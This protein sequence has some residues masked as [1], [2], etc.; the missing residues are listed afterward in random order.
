MIQKNNRSPLIKR[1]PVPKPAL[2]LVNN[3]DI[4]ETV[5][6]IE[7][8]PTIKV[9]QKITK[10]NSKLGGIFLYTGTIF[11]ILTAIFFIILYFVYLHGLPSIKTIEDTALPET[12]IIYDRNGK[13]IYR[14]YTDEKRTYVPYTN[15]S[16][17]MLNAI[18]SA[19]DK[20]FFENQGFD[21]KGILRAG[22]S[23]VSGKSDKI[24]GT[25]TIS[26]QLI[27]NT[28]LSNE[29]SIKRKVQEVY[30]S[31]NLNKNY[32]K[33]KIL[34]LYLNKISFGNNAFGIEEASRTFFGKS[35]SELGILGSSILASIPKGPTYYSPYTH[36]DRLMGSFYIYGKD[37]P[38]ET[39]KIETD[40]KRA[41]YQ[42]FIDKFKD[43]LGKMTFKKVDTNTVQVCNLDQK[44]FK[45]EFKIGT[46]KCK[47]VNYSDLFTMLNSISIKYIELYP[48]SKDED[49]QDIVFEYEAGRKDF[50]LGRM[51]EDEKIKGD[52]Y[53]N[54]VIGGVDFRFKKNIEA[55]KY[56]YFI[57]Y[58]KEYLE[59]KYGKEFEAQGGLRIY[60]TLDS[61]M[62]DKA[63]EIINTKAKTYPSKF[64]ASDAALVSID[65]K[66]GQVMALVGGV[67]YFN[68]DKGA[69][70]N[71]ITSKR[72]PGSSFKPIE[73]ALAISKYPIS[74]ESPIYD[75]KTKFGGW[76]PDNY[77]QKFLGKLTVAKALD[78]SRNIPAAKMFVVAGGEENV[79]DFANNLGIDSLEQGKSYGV[80]L[81]IGAGEVKPI[82]MAQAYS[83]FANYGYKKEITPVLKIEDRKGNM[84]D[85]YYESKG[86]SIFSEA[87]SYI[88]SKILSDA[89]SRPNAFRNQNLTLKGRPVA[90]KT[91]T[92][93][94]VI[95]KGKNKTIL[96]G[97]LWTC[98]YTPQFTTIVW[99]G[100]VDGS[101]MK[102]N[103]DGL[104]VAA[105]I[106][107]DYMEFAHKGL[108][109]ENFQ[110]P[111]GVFDATISRASGRLASSTTPSSMKVTSI[112]AVKPTEY[113]K[114]DGKVIEVDTLCNGKATENTPPD[115]IKKIYLGSK[116][117][118]IDSFN[119][120]WLAAIKSHVSSGTMESDDGSTANIN[121]KDEP[122]ERP[123]KDIV[124]M[125]FSTNIG[126]TLK[127][128]NNNLEVSYTAN[129]PI[130]KVEVFIDGTLHKSY[131][132][133]GASD[134]IFKTGLNLGNIGGTHDITVKLIDKYSYSKDKSYSV[135]LSSS[136]GGDTT[137]EGGNS[138]G[139]GG[140]IGIDDIINNMSSGTIDAGNQ[141]SVVINKKGPTISIANP[142]GGN[143]NIYE[144]QFF[145]LR[146][147]VSG[148]GLKSINVYVDGKLLNSGTSVSIA[149]PINGDKDLEV[150]KHN[151][152]IEAIDKDGNKSIASVSV[153][154]MSR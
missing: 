55:I 120:D 28:F 113:D 47:N 103:A 1:R 46:D 122:C 44:F 118:Y 112:F 26:Q 143:I 12:N 138:P 105:P 72:Q 68:E 108:K 33:E 52:D 109:V 127:S 15:I 130:T 101:A 111:E 149:V 80:P 7:K 145:N 16:K 91:G 151:V 96:P 27:K 87:A 4:A 14:L 131:D 30:L 36:R 2:K 69:Q 137:G 75:L 102:A 18:V 133:D 147:S 154:V 38:K 124:N 121:Y 77:D 106:W 83:T 13:E 53:K 90:A 79:V 22:I 66:T 104:N 64:G 34:E 117:P 71:I 61:N 17:N 140:D 141:S 81:A 24:Q 73:Y 48:D 21:L 57:F 51:F 100:N 59:N 49:L 31:Y 43:I 153:N 8:K 152:S 10:S 58:L 88:L 56:P 85:G 99:V 125:S 20:T 134:G 19:E 76:T 89:S 63:E 128:G 67:D 115:A 29:R 50:V 78:Y 135:S 40:E 129:T 54:N 107:H 150:G 132:L 39:E 110:R 97:D 119:K 116:S 84:I 148:L 35:A 98:G 62:Q 95:M 126:S 65:N 60:T 25:S 144:D 94:K 23:Y 41:K 92:S 42:F 3:S 74:P 70:V 123:G 142:K 139:E 45:N 5:E 114:G 6:N 11:A 82:E 93:N 9:P 86:R 32:S 136:G 146:G 37:T